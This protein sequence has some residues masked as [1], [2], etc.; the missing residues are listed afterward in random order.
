MKT[1]LGFWGIAISKQDNMTT[2]STN[3]ILVNF[4]RD[5]KIRNIYNFYLLV[6]VRSL[7][8]YQIYS[9]VPYFKNITV[10][11]NDH[12]LRSYMKTG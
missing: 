3:V 4:N 12:D 9:W 5:D 6:L 1:N 11:Y 7:L 8:K 2:K 10:L